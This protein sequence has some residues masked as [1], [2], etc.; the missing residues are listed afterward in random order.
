MQPPVTIPNSTSHVG[1]SDL[2]NEMNTS[3]S[4][5]NSRDYYKVTYSRDDNMD[6]HEILDNE[7]EFNA[8]QFKLYDDFTTDLRISFNPL[9][10][11]YHEIR[12]NRR[13][14]DPND[15]GVDMENGN[16]RVST[17]RDCD[18]VS[19]RCHASIIGVGDPLAL[20]EE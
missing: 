19:C 4:K 14:G 17:S 16:T 6:S 8:N 13:R 9:R 3:D 5:M 15:S 12:D 2:H 11:N 10:N 1:S 7:T 20:C 18:L